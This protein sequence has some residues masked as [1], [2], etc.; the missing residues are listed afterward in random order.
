MSPISNDKLYKLIQ[1]LS[2]KINKL[3]DKVDY[4]TNIILNLTKENNIFNETISN[5]Q[6]KNNNSIDIDTIT[7]TLKDIE[8]NKDIANNI[9][10]TNTNT[11]FNLKT[12]FNN[13]NSFTDFINKKLDTKLS[14][15]N[16]LN[17]H[18]LNTYNNKKS[19]TDDVLDDIECTKYIS[20]L[21]SLETKL[22]IFKNKNKLFDTKIYI[23]QQLNVNTHNIFYKTR[24]LRK[25]G[26]INKTWIYKDTVYINTNKEDLKSIISINNINQLDKY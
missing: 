18:K 22:K 19:E 9:I 13:T 8:N 16:I 11:D 15:N 23:S 1:D 14:Y 3:N 10:F 2:D 5:S 25:A 21:D 12:D 17:I 20:K 24:Q 4:Q 6:I 7:N 26:K